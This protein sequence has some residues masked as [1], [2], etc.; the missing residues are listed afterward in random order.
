L[1]TKIRFAKQ[2]SCMIFYLFFYYNPPI[3]LNYI[4][5]PLH[6]ARYGA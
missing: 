4:S 1:L 5:R 3:H 6:K 2:T